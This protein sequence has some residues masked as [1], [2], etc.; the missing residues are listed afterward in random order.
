M[1][2]ALR[3]HTRDSRRTLQ[4]VY[5]ERELPQPSH[6]TY[7]TGAEV[8][9]FS[10]L[11]R[12][13]IMSSHNR[14]L[15]MAGKMRTGGT[16]DNWV[17]YLTHPLVVVGFVLLLAFR[18][19]QGFL[20]RNII[21]QLDRKT[22]GQIARLLLRDVFWIAIPVIIFGFGYALFQTHRQSS[23]GVQ[24]GQAENTRLSGLAATATST[25][26]QRPSRTG[27]TDTAF[28]E[29]VR[30]CTDAI[31]ALANP[32]GQ[33][34]KVADVAQI[35]TAL[36]D[37]AQGDSEK[38]KAIFTKV[39][40]QKSAEGSKANLEAAAAA[41]HL[42]ALAFKDDT[43]VALDAYQKMVKLAPDEPAGWGGLGHVYLRIGKLND[44]EAAFNHVRRIGEGRNNPTILGGAYHY[45][46][47]IFLRRGEWGQAE[48]M[49]KKALALHEE[50]GDKH[51]IAADYGDL[52]AIYIDRD[53]TQAEAM[54]KKALS[55][56]EILGDKENI[57]VNYGNLGSVYLNRG[58]LAQAEAMHKK[59]LA[60][61]EL[62]GIKEGIARNYGHLGNVYEE[63]G[64]Y[65]VAETMHTKAKVLNEAI[66]HK[67]GMA[68]N[69]LD[70]GA[71]YL[72]R[73]DLA[74][75][76][77]M[78][79]KA[80][81]ITT[82][83]SAYKEN[84]VIAARGMGEVYLLRGRLDQAETVLKTALE[85][86]EALGSKEGMAGDYDVLG[87]VAQA[88]GEFNL[89]E[90]R[91]RKAI[92]LAEAS[93]KK[94][95]S[96]GV[97]VNLGSIFLSKGDLAQ[98][99]TTIMKAIALN[100]SLGQKFSLANAH[101]TL[102]RIN[103][104]R[105]DLARA[106]AMYRKALSIFLA[107]GGHINIAAVYSNL[108]D[109]LRRRN[110]LAQAETM[111]T[112]ALELYK[113]RD[114]KHGISTQYLN[115]GVVYENR[116]DLAQ[117]EVLYKRSATLKE[118]LGDKEGLAIIYGNLGNVYYARKHLAQA[119]GMYLKSLELAREIRL[120]EYAKKVEGWLNDVYFLKQA[121]GQ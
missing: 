71:L 92:E 68:A 3:H 46:A 26:C 74:Q 102:G 84:S 54:L 116:E 49:M 94:V 79:S 93:G 100:E 117:A 61:N 107:M 120:D 63:R 112:K 51:A 16:F 113:A 33:E 34:S 103:E 78:Y 56:S 43:D 32:N 65:V 85:L 86:H 4:G 77:E 119:E 66:D 109:L 35:E 83:G 114:D 14:R 45:L 17:P 28:E 1:S 64:D 44:A 110:D 19:Y 38:A 91:F 60:L 98:A 42:G 96:A 36:K 53:D 108:G 15:A 89:A 40:E 101:A 50:A 97:F 111:L 72:G 39:L 70:L 88:R 121:Y 8:P 106:E 30:A 23:P 80:L 76:E 29:M 2:K 22:G 5:E 12:S 24:K 41:F 69:Y 20:T 118:E 6:T 75:A 87:L 104:K 37:L 58:D 59:S 105:G 9:E 115:L 31:H 13:R 27:F 82:D 10:N 7:S 18:V 21:P 55:L 81:A 25:F 47:Q 95:I 90:A 48:S 99:E 52:G 57:A 67:V 73:G 62:L 11:T